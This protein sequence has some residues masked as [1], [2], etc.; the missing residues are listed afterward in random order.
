MTLW[1]ARLGFFN[2]EEIKDFSLATLGGGL[3]Y[4][5]RF[6][7]KGPILPYEMFHTDTHTHTHTLELLLHR[8]LLPP[9]L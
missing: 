4:P 2:L 8:L 1:I 9:M 3:S 5:T 6:A 7:R